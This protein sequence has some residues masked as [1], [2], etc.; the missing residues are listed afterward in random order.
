MQ[1]VAFGKSDLFLSQ[2][3][4]L[5]LLSN[6]LIIIIPFKTEVNFERLEGDYFKPLTPVNGEDDSK[7]ALKYQQKSTLPTLPFGELSESAS[8]TR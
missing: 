4:V 2:N 1:L 5:P 8:L 6:C 3:G 7:L